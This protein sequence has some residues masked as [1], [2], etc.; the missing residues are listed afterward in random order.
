MVGAGRGRRLRP[1]QVSFSDPRHG[2]ALI[3]HLALL[4][5]VDGGQVWSVVRPTDTRDLLTGLATVDAPPVQVSERS[6]QQAHQAGSSKRRGNAEQR[7]SQVTRG[8]LALAVRKGGEG[9]LSEVRR[10][11]PA[12]LHA[13]LRLPRRPGR[14]R[15][16]ARGH[17]RAGRARSGSAHRPVWVYRSTQRGRL[18]LAESLLR[19]AGIPFVASGEHMQQLTG[20]DVFGPAE[21]Y[22]SAADADDARAVLADLDRQG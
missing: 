19:S 7:R 15:R 22:V 14:A 21:L 5:T 8:A 18:P 6:V 4:A 3:G 17:L 10:G 13:V 1:R 9:D 2:W 11:V 16:S 12:R 20:L